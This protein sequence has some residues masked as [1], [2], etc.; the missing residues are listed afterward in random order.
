[1]AR[2]TPR[3][4]PTPRRRPRSLWLPQLAIRIRTAGRT[5]RSVGLIDDGTPSNHTN[6]GN[7]APDQYNHLA[8]RTAG[9]FDRSPM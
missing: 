9:G 3:T 6:V 4:R 8:N 7:S 1:M 5:S 2:S